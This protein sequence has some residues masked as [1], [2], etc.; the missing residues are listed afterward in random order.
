MLAAWVSARPTQTRRESKESAPDRKHACSRHPDVDNPGLTG[1]ADYSEVMAELDYAFLADFARV[2]PNGTLT[3]IGASWTFV[4]AVLLPSV[5]RMAVA[6][7]IR[8]KKEAGPVVIRVAI[9]G[10]GD[11]F[12]LAA[13]SEIAASPATRP[14]GSGLV[15]H[16]FAW[17][18]EVPLPNEGVYSIYIDVDGERARRL[19]F[20][21]VR[22]A[23]QR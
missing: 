20:E 13:D 10:P 9:H 16:L 19:A 7:R 12:T 15:G 21:V 8:A 14:Y 3:A 22:S 17:N 23:D 2:D 4:H 1:A 5:H 6:G 11:A 18:L